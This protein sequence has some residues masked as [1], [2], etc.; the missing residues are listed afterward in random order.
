MQPSVAALAARF[1]GVQTGVAGSTTERVAGID[2]LMP[3]A[4][5]WRM[6]AEASGASAPGHTCRLLSWV[7]TRR[8]LVMISKCPG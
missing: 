2:G 4:L 8:E 1:R 5:D 7:T 6:V 3:D